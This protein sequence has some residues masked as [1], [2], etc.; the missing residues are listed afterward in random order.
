MDKEMF[1][2]CFAQRDNLIGRHCFVRDKYSHD[3]IGTITKVTDCS[4]IYK[5]VHFCS[6]RKRGRFLD[7]VGRIDI[8]HCQNAFIEGQSDLWSKSRIK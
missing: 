6:C 8:N 7:A 4:I 3:R 2:V 1:K 5:Y